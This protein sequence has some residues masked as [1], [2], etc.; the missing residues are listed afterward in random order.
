MMQ[1]VNVYGCLSHTRARAHTR[2]HAHAHTHTH[3]HT[4]ARTHAHARSHA[5]T[6]ARTHTHTHTHARARA[7]TH[8]RSVSPLT[9]SADTKPILLWAMYFKWL[10]LSTYAKQHDCESFLQQ[11]LFLKATNDV[12]SVSGYFIFL[13]IYFQASS[14]FFRWFCNKVHL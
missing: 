3:A 8:A 4:H 7:R 6:H 1:I 2:T 11:C 14:Q 10:K 5:R 9:H 13:N 12:L